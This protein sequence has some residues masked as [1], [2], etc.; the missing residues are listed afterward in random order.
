MNEVSPISRPRAGR[1]T[2]EQAE[3]RHE[4]LLDH[5]LD[6]FLD[7]GFEQ[8]T[9]EAIAADVGMTKRTVYA[10]YPDKASLFRAAV[11]R[12]IARYAISEDRIHETEVPG[13]LA[14]TLT[15]IAMLR[16]DLVSSPQGLK[17][18]RIIQTESY[19][20]PE[21]FTDTYE[22]GAFPTIKFLAKLLRRETEAGNL[23]IEDTFAAANAFVSMVVTGPVKLILAAIPLPREELDQRVAFGV[24]LFLNGARPR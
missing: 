8:A 2:R 23:A 21:I 10:R 13:D 17:L 4:E 22:I 12:A 9:I 15:N 18:Q 20:F 16:I 14:Q 7:K 24:N 6:H 11:N 1:P 5:A 19:R 3:A